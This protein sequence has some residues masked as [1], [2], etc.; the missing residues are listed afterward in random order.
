M[1]DD[2]NMSHAFYRAMWGQDSPVMWLAAMVIASAIA[3]AYI[4]RD[5]IRQWLS[6]NRW[7]MINSTVWGGI[8]AICCGSLWA[9]W[10]WA[11]RP[12]SIWLYNTAFEDLGTIQIT[13]WLNINRFYAVAVGM[14]GL[15]LIVK[16]RRARRRQEYR[17]LRL[18]TTE[19]GRARM[20]PRPRHPGR[21]EVR[22]RMAR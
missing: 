17:P 5:S 3:S 6:D 15:Y 19:G 16:V 22:R 21:V 13:D 11:I 14:V 20:S 4:C 7:A 9:A 18:I 12:A 8:I 2:Y 1:N 10:V